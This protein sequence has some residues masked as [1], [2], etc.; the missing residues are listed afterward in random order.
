MAQIKRIRRKEFVRFFKE[1]IICDHCGNDTRG[2]CYAE[3]EKV[4]CSIC[5][6]T[7]LD[8]RLMEEE[9]KRITILFTPDGDDNDTK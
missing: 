5:Y 6:N 7:I 1:Y 3:T 8:A 9:D 2:R 4:V